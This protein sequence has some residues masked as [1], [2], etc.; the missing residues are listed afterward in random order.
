MD[1]K[2]LYGEEDCSQTG[3]DLFLSGRVVV[4][5]PE[6]RSGINQ[7]LFCENGADGISDAAD[8]PISAVSLAD[9]EYIRGK[10]GDI[11]GLLKPELLPDRARLQLSQ[12]RPLDT[13]ATET[14]EFTGYC[15]L[16][17][18]RYATGVPLADELEV[19][20]YIDIQ[21][22]CQH[23]VMICDREDCC[24]FEAVEGEVVFPTREMRERFLREDV[25]LEEPDSGG[26]KMQP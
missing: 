2:P 7:L 21:C 13:E 24:V 22:A 6:G 19:R 5:R 8:W 23:R 10:R 25:G 1:E 9:G 26:M 14:P 12:I 20:E 3:N 16:P 18:G 17:D 4:L 11:L 15:F